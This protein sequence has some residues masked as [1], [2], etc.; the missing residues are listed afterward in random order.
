MVSDGKALRGRR[1]DRVEAA[2]DDE[3]VVANAGALLV[4]TLADRLGL[5]ALIDE[6]VVLTVFLAG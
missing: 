6:T 4:A 1:L 5:E 3:R 2:F